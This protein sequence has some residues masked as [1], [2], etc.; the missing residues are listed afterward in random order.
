MYAA[1]QSAET[2]ALAANV[3]V[4]YDLEA[5]MAAYNAF[6]AVGSL[7]RGNV[8]LRVHPGTRSGHRQTIPIFLDILELVANKFRSR[9]LSL[10]AVVDPR[11]FFSVRLGF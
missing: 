11:Y 2:S 4:P 1:F 3:A 7:C 6:Q 5:D 9:I 10:S 8:P